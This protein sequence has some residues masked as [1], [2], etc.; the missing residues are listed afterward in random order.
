[1]SSFVYISSSGVV[2]AISGFWRYANSAC[3]WRRVCDCEIVNAITSIWNLSSLVHPMLYIVVVVG[4]ELESFKL[5]ACRRPLQRCSCSCCWSKWH[6]CRINPL[7]I[8]TGSRNANLWKKRLAV[9]SRVS[10]G[11]GRIFC[12]KTLRLGNG[13]SDCINDS[14]T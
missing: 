12:G 1:M 3:W 14:W 4:I 13:A 5:I 7:V 10:F 6:A 9:W 2:P 11:E 8:Q